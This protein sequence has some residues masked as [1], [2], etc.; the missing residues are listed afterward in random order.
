MFC[1]QCGKQLEEGQICGCQQMKSEQTEIKMDKAEE[2]RDV[3]ISVA[4]ISK[5]GMSGEVVTS[6]LEASNEAEHTGEVA[7]AVWQETVPQNFGAQEGRDMTYGAANYTY[8]NQTIP[9]QSTNY[10]YSNQPTS[11]QPMNAEGF[12]GEEYVKKSQDWMK[13]QS[14]KVLETS[15]VFWKV[16]QPL[17]KNPGEYA[18]ELSQKSSTLLLAQ[19]LIFKAFAVG[20]FLAIF[21]NSTIYS[22]RFGHGIL[23][24][25]LSIIFIGVGDLVRALFLKLGGILLKGK[26]PYKTAVG[27]VA[28]NNVFV[29]IYALCLTILALFLPNFSMALFLLLIPILLVME[30][31]LYNNMVDMPSEKK[32]FAFILGQSIYVVV[33]LLSLILLGHIIRAIVGAIF[34]GLMN[35][36]MRNIPYG[37][38]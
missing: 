14:Q 23:V 16:I 1:T 21:L 17:L 12:K 2:V 32:V 6:V 24:V 13:A 19:L 18:R 7:P 5:E 30:S 35:E 25:I 33:N 20:L 9:N 27:V 15:N 26:V 11:H 3:A 10:A 38:F 4:E 22:F 8:S 31:H 28:Y 37:T 29:T 34:G 36:L